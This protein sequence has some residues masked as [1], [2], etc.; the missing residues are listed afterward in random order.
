M[1]NALSEKSKPPA[2]T[3]EINSLRV[4]ALNRLYRRLECLQASGCAWELSICIFEDY[5]S[6]CYDTRLSYTD[7]T[8]SSSSSGGSDDNIMLIA[9]TAL[10]VASKYLDEDEFWFNIDRMSEV[11]PVVDQRLKASRY[12]LANFS[13]QQLLDKELE[14]LKALDYK[15]T[16]Y[17]PC[18]YW[19]KRKGDTRSYLRRLLIGLAYCRPELKSYYSS[20]SGTLVTVTSKLV[21]KK[22]IKRRHLQLAET[23]I[24]DFNRYCYD[25][26]NGDNDVE[27]LSDFYLRLV[28][29]A[30]LKNFLTRIQARHLTPAMFI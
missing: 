14:L 24:A 18:Y 3:D 28:G 29:S 11:L 16:H 17:K 23:L 12:R 2:I 30:T 13:K 21:N 25:V 1:G 9:M 10:M 5:W 6:H 7:T 20:Q 22:R 26:D 15:I 27:F 4:D 8:S 19:L